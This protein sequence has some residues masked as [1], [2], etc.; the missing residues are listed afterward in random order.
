MSPS[1][2]A[3]IATLLVSVI[4]SG[5]LFWGATVRRRA[6]NDALQS[7]R[8]EADRV[9]R[10]AERDAESLR[11]EAALEAREKAHEMAAEAERHSRE[12]RQEIVGLEQGLAEKMR[13]LADRL[14]ATDTVE[15]D[16]RARE[17]ALAGHDARAAAAAVRAEQLVVDRQRELQRVAGLSADEIGRAHV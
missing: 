2:L 17:K 11:K 3:S 5:A 8:T 14:A 10:Q 4:A 12:R 1:G 13:A 6:A 15:Q 9:A 16:L 7:A